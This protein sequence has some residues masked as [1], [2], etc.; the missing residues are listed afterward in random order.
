MTKRLR[1]LLALI[2]F[3]LFVSGFSAQDKSKRASKKVGRVIPNA[4]L[5]RTTPSQSRRIKDNQPY[6]Q[7]AF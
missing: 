4:P 2:A 7:Q 1:S 3:P 6:L 5:R